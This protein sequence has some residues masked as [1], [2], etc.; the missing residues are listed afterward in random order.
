MDIK[1]FLEQAIKE[2][3]SLSHLDLSEGTNLYDLVLL[4]LITV[5]E[6]KM[7]QD[8]IDGAGDNLDL[9][10]YADMTIDQL[11]VLAH[12]HLVALHEEVKTH[13]NITLFFSEPIDWNIPKDTSLKSGTHNFKIKNET[14]ITINNFANSPVN[15]LFE[16]LIPVAVE[17]TDGVDIEA[18]TLGHI[19]GSSS[20]L[21]KITHPAMLT[22][23][24]NYTNVELFNRIRSTIAPAESL[25][26]AGITNALAL[27]FSG[28]RKIEVVGAGESEMERDTIVNFTIGDG[29]SIRVSDFTG[30]IR[31]MKSETD[32]NKSSAYILYRQSPISNEIYASDGI[33]LTQTQYETIVSDK[34]ALDIAISTDDIFS[35]TF[36]QSSSVAGRTANI[37]SVGRELVGNEYFTTLTL[38]STTG[39]EPGNIINIKFYDAD[40]NLLPA[41]TGVIRTV[42]E[43]TLTLYSL[44][45][46]EEDEVDMSDPLPYVEIVTTEGFNLGNGWVS[47]EDG[48][49]LGVCLNKREVMIIDNELVLGSTSVDFSGNIV[50]E[51][52]LRMG[53]DKFVAAVNKGMDVKIQPILTPQ[54]EPAIQSN[55][56]TSMM[57]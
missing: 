27:R 40:F 22:G 16:Y 54:S 49:N 4:P 53:L 30:K 12:N 45:F 20:K 15:G 39:F 52:L 33:E 7:S 13:G 8:I 1:K 31:G 6:E 47:S 28:L 48:M 17:S 5:L 35:D 2:S 11:K 34:D 37:Q 41:K 56:Q 21:V 57:V 29:S 24:T 9:S 55:Q 3:P 18:N 43:T 25:T 38:L 26:K 10:N 23:V 51:T 14:N 19:E 44:I 42:D 36:T 46:N 50:L 32:N